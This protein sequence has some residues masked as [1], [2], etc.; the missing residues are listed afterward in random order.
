MKSTAF[1]LFHPVVALAYFAIL[2]VM[3][4]AAMQ[5]VYLLVSLAAALALGAVLR[6][7]RAVAMSLCQAPSY[8]VPGLD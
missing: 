3:S 2:L 5:P 4:M 8:S 6:G 7:V 1:D